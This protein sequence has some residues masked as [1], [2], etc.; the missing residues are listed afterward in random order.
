MA[1][2]KSAPIRFIEKKRRIKV[3]EENP[4][5]KTKTRVEQEMNK[6]KKKHEKRTK[7]YIE[8]TATT[9]TAV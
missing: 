9:T 6:E 1:K 2:K 8:T 3:D 4:P 7:K 5:L